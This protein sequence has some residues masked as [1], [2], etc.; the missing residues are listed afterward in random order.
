M[1]HL[2]QSGTYNNINDRLLDTFKN[3][4]N[5]QVSDVDIVMFQKSLYP[6]LSTAVENFHIAFHTFTYIVCLIACRVWI[7][8]QTLCW[9]TA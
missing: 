8:R 5:A 6:T 2:N 9:I 4:T 1:G 3:I 7:I